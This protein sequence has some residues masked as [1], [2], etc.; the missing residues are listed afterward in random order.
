MPPGPSASGPI[1]FSLNGVPERERP[2]VFREFFGRSVARVDV[3][4]LG[5]VPFEADLTLQAL[6]GLLVASGRLHGLRNRRTRAMAADG[7]DDFGLM[8]NLGGPYLVSQGEEELRLGEG[9]ATL[10]SCADPVTLTHYPP[11]HVLGLRIPRARLA[12]LVTRAEDCFLRRIPRGSE[13]L[14]LL[15][16]YIRIASDAQTL[17]S[18]RLQH[19]TVSHIHELAAVAIGATRDAAEMARDGGVRAARLHAIRLDISANLC[20][21]DLSV[22]ALALRHSCTPRFVQ[23]L[24]EREG[25]TFTDYLL[26]QRLARVHRMLSDP[27]RAGQKISTLAYDC[28]FGDLSY[29]NRA[30]RRH[31]GATPLDVRAQAHQVASA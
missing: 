9:E 31:Y 12:P 6:P 13:A 14:A 29:F 3:E 23:R 8:V 2:G 21:G 22:A 30:F 10:V 1:R 15:T 17:A 5:D 11:G 27:R 25:T 18:R 4:P 7:V 24:F 20:R 16:G 19:L 26:S 28:G